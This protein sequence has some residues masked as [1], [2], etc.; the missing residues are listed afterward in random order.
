MFVFCVVCCFIVLFVVSIQLFTI[1]L[2]VVAIQLFTGPFVLFI[3]NLAVYYLFT[4]CSCFWCLF[5]CLLL[6]SQTH[7][8][9]HTSLPP[10]SLLMPWPES[11][12]GVPL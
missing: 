7:Y 9:T 5:V 12:L 3:V 6:V 4:L 11:E 10:C 8:F 2:F 1:V